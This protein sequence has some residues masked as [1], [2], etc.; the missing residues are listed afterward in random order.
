MNSCDTVRLARDTLLRAL[1]D[2]LNDIAVKVGDLPQQC[3]E[4]RVYSALA[5]FAS[6]LRKAGMQE[7]A[8][9]VEA[10]REHYDI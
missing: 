4:C 2:V 5:D 8:S 10:V 3:R 7:E 1:T 6:R 9:I